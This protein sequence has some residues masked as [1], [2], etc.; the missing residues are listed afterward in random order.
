MIAALLWLA[1]AGGDTLAT[2]AERT[3]F[4]ETA[5]YDETVALARKLD[6]ASPWVTYTS[7]GA[8]GEG[9][10]LPLLVVAK[11]GAG[12]PAQAHAA[13][14]AVVLVINCIHAGE[15]EGKDA[16]L[17]LVRDL[18]QQRAALLEKVVLLVIPIYNVDG[19]ERFG[20]FNRIN[21]NGPREMGFRV[22]ARN[23]NLNR[24]FTKAD[25]P[26][27]RALLRLWNAWRPDLFFDNHTT[28]GAD[29]QYDVLY[30]TPVWQTQH[31]AVVRW[32]RQH[33]VERAFPALAQDGH[34]VGPNFSLRDSR[35]PM[36]G[37]EDGDLPPR[38][39]SGFATL[40]NRPSILVETHMMKPYRQRVMA[41]YHLMRRVLDELAADP[42]S[43]R[44][45][46]GEA[47]R[48]VSGWASS[49]DPGRQVTLL[50]R[51]TEASVPFTLRGYGYTVSKSKISGADAIVW[52]RSKPVDYATRLFAQ[53]EPAVRVA[54]PL[55]YVI[56]VEWPEVAE[57]LRL[58]GLKVEALQAP[59][60]VEI[61]SYRIAEPEWQSTSF[62]GRLP[63]SKFR[64]EPLRE[65]RPF[66]RGSFLVRLDQPQGKAALHL[67]EPEAPDSLLRWGEFHAT[68]EQKEHAE[69]YVMEAEAARM[70]AQSPALKNEF[71]KALAADPKLAASPRERL[72]FF[73]RRSAYWDA[74]VGRY[75][76]G[77]IVDAAA[78][79]A[80]RSR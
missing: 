42:G 4:V 40:H 79:R 3:D 16:S 38:F 43:L 73:F 35:N 78:L 65:R 59:A 1:A 62:E 34:V 67:L 10:A 64:A 52:D 44:A 24:D 68:L 25:A 21:Q 66:A 26:E 45:A 17:M 61:E 54:P 18:V 69:A 71:E 77:R 75:P 23:L 20:P 28:D 53:A 51:R 41:T 2:R 13:G 80:L 31:P 56:P 48:E 76:V 29:W 15:V 39:S 19:H 9:R 8:S 47:D 5:R 14:R 60:E 32:S 11:P 30:S 63:L 37:L 55:A 70:L 36:A 57:R 22:N 6:A 58:Q 7:F 33:L 74:R 50:V 46:L 27:T 72:D 49:Y 12:T